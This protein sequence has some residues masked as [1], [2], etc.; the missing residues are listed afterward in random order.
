MNILQVT[1]S[2]EKRKCTDCL[3]CKVSMKS[4]E[5]N[6]LCFCSKIG[7]KAVISETYWLKKPVCVNFND[8]SA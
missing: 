2:A 5:D 6:R 3:N 4:T 8:M 1:E 7:R